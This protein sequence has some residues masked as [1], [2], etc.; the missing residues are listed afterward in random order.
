MSI[1]LMAPNGLPIVGTAE[2]AIGVAYL[3]VLRRDGDGIE[4]QHSGSTDGFYDNQDTV[5]HAPGGITLCED[6]DGNWWR[7]DRLVPIG[8]EVPDPVPVPDVWVG[9]HPTMAEA[10]KLRAEN[11]RLRAA[12]VLVDALLRK[13]TNAGMLDQLAIAIHPDEINRV[14]DEVGAALAEGAR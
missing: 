4:M 14:C 13:A 5:A 11:A 6:G 7:W 2:A 8:S 1:D 12:L 9:D 3:S 10:L